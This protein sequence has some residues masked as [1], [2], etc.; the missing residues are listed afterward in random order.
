MYQAATKVNVLSLVIYDIIGAEVF[1]FIRRQYVS[2]RFGKVSPSYRDLRQWHDTRWNLS[3]L[4]RS[5]GFFSRGKSMR[6]QVI[7]G[8][9]SQMSHW[10]SDSLIVLGAGERPVR[11]EAVRREVVEFSSG[12]NTLRGIGL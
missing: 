10:K 1:H 7:S 4:G 3:E 2:S 12:H 6:G 11:G 8:E 9:K 5:N